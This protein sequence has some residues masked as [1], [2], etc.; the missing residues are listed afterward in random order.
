ML[1][2]KYSNLAIIIAQL[3][4]QKKSKSDLSKMGFF[5]NFAKYLKRHHFTLKKLLDLNYF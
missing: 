5:S 2:K 1:M 4:N 3:I